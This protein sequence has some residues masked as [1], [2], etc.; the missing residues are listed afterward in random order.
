M[1]SQIQLYSKF[2][3]TLLGASLIIASTLLNTAG[4]AGL[5][6]PSNGQLPDL[7]IKE[8]HVNVVINNGYATTHIE[9]VFHNP[10]NT[11]LEAIYSFPVPAKAAVGEFVYWVN[12]QAII[13]EVVEKQRAREIYQQE[14]QAG[15]NTALVEQDSFKTFDIAVYPVQ[16]N[17]DTRVKLSY[18]QA[19][20]T[21]NNIARYVYPLEEGGV[22]E[23]KLSFWTRNEVVTEKFS[24]NVHLRSAYPVSSL[25]LPKHPQAQTHS[26]SP[27][28]WQVSL[29][30]NTQPSTPAIESTEN[31]HS[32]T[33][34]AMHLN[35]D[36]VLYWR[37]AD[38]TPGSVD[39]VSYKNKN[40]SQG[41]FMLTLTPG[42]D[43]SKVQQG[44]DW[45]FVLDVS[46]SM[47][48]KYASLVEGIKQSLNKLPS[49]DRF[50]I[51]LFN[52]KATDISRG[53]HNA[54]TENIQRMLNFMTHYQPDGSTN[55]YAG[56][57]KATQHLDTDRSTAIILVTDG[58][59]N[60]GKTGR[61]DFIKLLKNNDVRLFTFIM[62]NSANRPLL[63]EMTTV[64]NGFALSVSNADDIVGK[65]MQASSKITHQA[66][67]NI[68]LDIDGVRTS[69]VTPKHIGS[70]YRGEQLIIFGHYYGSGTAEV[71]LNGLVGTE[72]RQ[73]KTRIN[74]PEAASDNPELERLWAY[75]YIEYLQS[76]L[77][78][79][80]ADAD[81]EQAITDTALQYGLVTE[82]TSMLVV[83]ESVFQQLN[84]QRNNQQRVSQEHAARQQR[85]QQAIQT[86]RA[87]QKS[88]MFHN[89][90]RPAFSGGGSSGGGAFDAWSI[91]LFIMLLL[92]KAVRFY[93]Q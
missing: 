81:T 23:A 82:Y 4:A 86:T 29:N 79:Y 44:R 22:D 52:Q 46:G 73:Y 9:Q 84:I 80:G 60:V 5:L 61:K 87:D 69:N 13:A 75:A 38:N 41:T 3:Q 32:D 48:G 14:K 47:R 55:L 25:R 85:A 1:T 26:I 21:D 43:L 77:D 90:P 16:A 36:I 12:G 91:L 62:G 24:F 50:Q 49:H 7:S 30:N 65:I 54:S 68:K 88:P 53:M 40:Q 10:N 72:Q 6:K 59:A 78:Y 19:I 45:I 27:Q 70:L 63:E 66:L 17:S 37:L 28:E 39:L 34:E 42:D 31:N 67:R 35:Q 51:I 20:N 74:F 18:I 2:I 15:R 71:S 57:E 56:L 11:A 58:V 83:E 8:H 92:P 93:R 33:T 76:Q 89:K 64:S